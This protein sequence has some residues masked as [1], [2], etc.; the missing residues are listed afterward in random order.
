MQ[1]SVLSNSR[2]QKRLLRSTLLMTV[3][4]F[5]AD[6]KAR[7]MALADDQVRGAV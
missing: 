2:L 7:A 1:N 3:F 6:K 5:G 4:I